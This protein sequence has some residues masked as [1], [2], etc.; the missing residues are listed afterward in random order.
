MKV[1]FKEQNAWMRNLVTFSRYDLAV[2][3][4]SMEDRGSA[5]VSDNNKLRWIILWRFC[6][7]FKDE[8]ISMINFDFV[9]V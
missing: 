1:N 4:D 7:I 5:C 8:F 9:R 2:L 6:D 3:E